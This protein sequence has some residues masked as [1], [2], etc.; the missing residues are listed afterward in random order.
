M[1]EGSGD[2]IIRGGSV[3]FVFSEAMFPELA[4]DM[5]ISTRRLRASR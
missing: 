1:G 3:E 2:I 4:A 5:A